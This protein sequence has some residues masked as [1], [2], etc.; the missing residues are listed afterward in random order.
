ML[1]FYL[2]FLFL[3]TIK[4]VKASIE[5]LVNEKSGKRNNLEISKC[6]CVLNTDKFFVHSCLML[7]WVSWCLIGALLCTSD[8]HSPWQAGLSPQAAGLV[9]SICDSNREA[10]F[11][12]PGIFAQRP[13]SVNRWKI[14]IFFTVEGL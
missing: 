13:G 9:M 11:I 10:R 1:L 12:F 14:D 6:L 8:L 3:F 2:L 4:K 5:N 7:T